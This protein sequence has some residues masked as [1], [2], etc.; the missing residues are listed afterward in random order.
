MKRLTRLIL[1]MSVFPCAASS[2]AAQYQFEVDKTSLAGYANTWLLGIADDGTKYE[3]ASNQAGTAAMSYIDRHGSIEPLTNPGQF[4]PSDIATDGLMSGTSFYN[5]TNTVVPAL[6]KRDGQLELIHLPAGS[7]AQGNGVSNSGWVA[8]NYVDNSYVS[9]G[10]LYHGGKTAIYDYP[11]SIYTVL[12]D[13]N[14]SGLATG[15]AYTSGS[16]YVAFVTDGKK[17]TPVETGLDPLSQFIPRFINNSGTI[18][19]SVLTYT[20]EDGW[21]EIPAVCDKKSVTTINTPKSWPA[22]IESVQNGLPT[23]LQYAFSRDELTSLN[24]KGEV[25]VVSIAS[26]V[27]ASNP[28]LEY[29]FVE[30]YVGHPV[31]V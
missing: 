1:A 5:S 23:T 29:T 25:S 6:R 16:G 31:K 10:F 3:N 14:N 22:T 7:S 8:G 4:S 18:A 26:Y 21:T 12:N 30:S 19:G 24:D 20:D 9:H 28:W 15:Y 17:A 27:D 11:G 13:V 2:T